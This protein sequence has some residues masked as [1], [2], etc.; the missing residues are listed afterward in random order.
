VK[1]PEG[2][3]EEYAL[4]WA[5][6]EVVQLTQLVNRLMDEVAALHDE[7]ERLEEVKANRAGRQKTDIPK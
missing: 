1:L 4:R 2:W 6:A 3:T 7:V 5:V